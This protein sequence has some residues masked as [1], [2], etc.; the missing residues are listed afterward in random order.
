MILKF[1]LPVNDTW[2]P[3]VIS[4]LVAADEFIHGKQATAG[5]GSRAHAG[6]GP[7]RRGGPTEEGNGRRG[8][9]RAG[10]CH[11]WR[12]HSPRRTSRGRERPAGWRSRREG[13]RCEEPLAEEGSADQAS[14]AQPAQRTCSPRKGTATGVLAPAGA[15]GSG[16]GAAGEAP[17]ERTTAPGEVHPRRGAA[18]ERGRQQPR[19]AHGRG[20][21]REAKEREKRMGKIGSQICWP[22]RC[23]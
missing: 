11:D 17:R 20:K 14:L 12:S 15:A 18:A 2:D 16:V 13:S 3:H 19:V 9:V 5:D 4:F 23:R 1:I 8:G 21:S 7:A 10:R 22:K 6:R